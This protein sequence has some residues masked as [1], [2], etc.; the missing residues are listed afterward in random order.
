MAREG[1]TTMSKQKIDLLDAL[2]LEIQDLRRKIDSTRKR[3][4]RSAEEAAKDVQE[5]AARLREGVLPAGKSF[6]FLNLY[7][8]VGELRA[9]TDRL[10]SLEAL[11]KETA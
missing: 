4:I 10:V 5:V 11:T 2:E 1:E 7:E 8:D 3:A 9:L 6:A